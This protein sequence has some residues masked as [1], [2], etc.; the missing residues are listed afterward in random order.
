MG[1]ELP[2]VQLALLIGQVPLKQING[3]R[4]RIVNFDPIVAIAVF[5][6]QKALVSG[7][8]LGDQRIADRHD[9]HPA[10]LERFEARPL[11]VMR[12]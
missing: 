8:E 5:V 11:L 4:T 12:R 1:W 2:L 9:Q 7:H 6:R 3:I 10:R